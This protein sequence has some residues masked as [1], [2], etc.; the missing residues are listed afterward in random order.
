M[1]HA[2]GDEVTTAAGQKRFGMNS[3]Q[4]GWQGWHRVEAVHQPEGGAD[5]GVEGLAKHLVG[6]PRASK[7]DAPD[8]SVGVLQCRPGS[9]CSKPKPD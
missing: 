5:Q 3:Q 9:S 4:G 2:H 1:S 6:H 8:V 7:G